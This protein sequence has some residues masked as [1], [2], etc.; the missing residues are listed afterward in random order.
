MEAKDSLDSSSPSPEQRGVELLEHRQALYQR[1]VVILNRMV[2]GEHAS[3][4]IVHQ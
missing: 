4:H 1:E 3:L 2:V